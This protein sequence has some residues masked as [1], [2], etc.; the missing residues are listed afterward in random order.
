M[1][2]ILPS[3]IYRISSKTGHKHC[4]FRETNYNVGF[5]VHEYA[6]KVVDNIGFNSEIQV[7]Q[8]NPY[9]FSTM[10]IEKNKVINNEIKPYLSKTDLIDFMTLPFVSDMGI[11]MIYDMLDENDDAFIM[12]AHV[13]ESSM[14]ADAVKD[15]L[16]RLFKK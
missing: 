3:T 8:H 2:F 12:D 11:I 1:S 16:D 14:S 13:I 10:R 4:R 7:L 5:M 9:K 15:R 6:T